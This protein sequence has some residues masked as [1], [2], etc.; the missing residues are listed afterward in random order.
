[1]ALPAALGSSSGTEVPPP[2]TTVPLPLWPHP[3]RCL[4]HDQLQADASGVGLNIQAPMTTDK[5][6]IKRFMTLLPPLRG[7]QQ[8][9]TCV[10]DPEDHRKRRTSGLCSIYRLFVTSRSIHPNVVI[11]LTLSRCIVLIDDAVAIRIRRAAGP[12]PSLHARSGRST[13]PQ[14]VGAA[15]RLGCLWLP[16]WSW[17]RGRVYHKAPGEPRNFLGFSPG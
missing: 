6:R 9:F 16:T 10:R 8:L 5:P 14:T 11:M 2:P 15:S 3:E 13:S 1:M 12:T 4:C 7:Q 17:P